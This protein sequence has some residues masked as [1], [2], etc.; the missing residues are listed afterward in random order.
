[1]KLDSFRNF[2]DSMGIFD[3][4]QNMEKYGKLAIDSGLKTSVALK[5]RILGRVTLANHHL[6]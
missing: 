3:V 4:G 2:W 1:M 6:F 5:V